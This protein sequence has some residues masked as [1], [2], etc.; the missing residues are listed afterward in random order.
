MR[1]ARCQLS[2]HELFLGYGH[3]FADENA[4]FAYKVSDFSI[5]PPN[6]LLYL[7][8]TTLLLY[9][10][11]MGLPHQSTSDNSNIVERKKKRK[12]LFA[13]LKLVT[14]TIPIVDELYRKNYSPEK[15]LVL[16]YLGQFSISRAREREKTL[17]GWS[18]LLRSRLGRWYRPIFF[19]G[20]FFPFFRTIILILSS[21]KCEWSNSRSCKVF[22]RVVIR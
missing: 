1:A 8:Y 6:L 21:A 4:D 11:S 17:A 7:R 19:F 22:Q 14:Y 15:I 13:R 18:I 16:Q 20:K 2:K 5:L 12:Q 10:H 3:N 9:S